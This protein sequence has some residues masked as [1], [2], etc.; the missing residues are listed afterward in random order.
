MTIHGSKGLE[1]DYVFII[2]DT[3]GIMPSLHGQPQNVDKDPH[4]SYELKAGEKLLI[5]SEDVIYTI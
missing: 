4:I 2:G 3:N 1:F 5:T